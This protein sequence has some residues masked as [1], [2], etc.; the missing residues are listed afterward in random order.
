MAANRADDARELGASPAD[1]L[2][3]QT[4]TFHDCMQQSVK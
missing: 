4:D 2:K 1:Q 3:V